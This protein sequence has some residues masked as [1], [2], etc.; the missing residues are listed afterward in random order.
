MNISKI[1]YNSLI[2]KVIRSP[3]KLIPKNAVLPIMQG[4]L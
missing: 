2:G 4:K 3:L 1:N